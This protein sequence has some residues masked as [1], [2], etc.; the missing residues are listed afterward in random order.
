MITEIG[1]KQ[2]L[3]LSIFVTFTANIPILKIG[4]FSLSFFFGIILIVFIL[5]KKHG[6]LFVDRSLIGLFFLVL[7][8]LFGLIL[9]PVEF[10]GGSIFSGIQICYWIILATIYAN[11]CKIVEVKSYQV[12][13]LIILIFLFLVFLRYPGENGPLSQNES[14]Y[15][16]VSLWPF[17][18]ELFKN[19]KRIIY[20]IFSVILIYLIGSRTGLIICLLQLGTFFALSKFSSKT[21]IRF[22][23]IFGL[24][25]VLISNINVRKYAAEKLFPEALDMQILIENPNIAFQMDKSWVQRRIQQEKCKQVFNKYPIIGIGPF[26]VEKYKIYIDPSNIKDVDDR[27][28]YIEYQHSTNR[29]AHNSYYQLLAENGIVGMIIIII[30]LYKVFYGLYKKKN[31]SEIYRIIL[32]SA[33]GL[34]FNLYMVSAFWGTNTWI[35]LGIYIGYSRNNSSCRVTKKTLIPM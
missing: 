6:Y 31:I 23:M 30:L 2:I 4:P 25:F 21:I 10:N 13:N 8:S 32:I 35:L 16:A 9:S 7:V 33:I 19:K 28:F 34:F 14:S 24:G 26:N 29:S 20:I 3:S 27:I 22:L 18:L 5:L 1:N 15:I 12:S 11:I 17:G